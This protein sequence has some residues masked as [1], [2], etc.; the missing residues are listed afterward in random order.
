MRTKLIVLLLSSI[1]LLQTSCK[2]KPDFVE[3]G[4]VIIS[5]KVINYKKH[6]DFKTFNIYYHNLFNTQLIKTVHIN[7]SGTFKSVIPCDAKMDFFIGFGH[8]P[9]YIICAPNDSLYIT[10][11]ADI[12]NDPK[13]HFPN[14]SYFVKVMGGTRVQDNYLVNAYI[15]AIGKNK[16]NRDEYFKT[17]ESSSPIDYLAFQ[18]KRLQM[19]M[20][21][22]D[23]ISQSSNTYLFTEWAND[24]S[25]Y[26]KLVKLLK[27]P[28]L[29]ARLVGVHQDSIA[30]PNEFYNKIFKRD[31][32]EHN[33]F[34]FY[35]NAFLNSYFIYLYKAARNSSSDI[36]QFIEKNANG[37]TKDI[38]ISKY[39]IQKNKTND[40][41]V[42]INYDLIK[43]NYLRHT[44]KAE[45]KNKNDKKTELKK[46]RTKSTIIDSLFSQYKGKVVYVDIWATWC[47]PCLNEMPKSIKLQNKFKNKPIEFLY[48]C[49]QSKYENWQSIIRKNKIKGKHVFI[50]SKQFNELKTL[51]DI[52][53]V[54]HYLIVD[55]M[56]GIIN[57]AP[58]PSSMKIQ[59]I[60]DR[61]I[62]NNA[63]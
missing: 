42:K 49:V 63:P 8:T 56:G 34:S 47:G 16:L 60:L 62:T 14:N 43:N 24:F 18:E 40:T 10:I 15:S 57:N 11:D 30:I 37:F 53:G 54:P 6:K 26:D 17:I 52:T 45:I 44:L 19:E 29:K 32:N 21:I 1:L 31:I 12:L 13:N 4:S 50:N 22:L 36:L 58:R 28:R 35:H 59:K 9:S 20:N 51:F 48:L 25:K 7:E 23:S 27:Y 61:M 41:S 3:N 39:F 33:I 5:G 55:K 2:N 38:A 46:Q